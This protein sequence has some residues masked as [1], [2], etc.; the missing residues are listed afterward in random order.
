MEEV[1]L[2][3]LLRVL[4]KRWWILALCAAILG[5]VAYVYTNYYIVPIYESY[6]TLY[7]GK[8]AE[9]NGLAMSD[10]YLGS[11]LISDYREIAKSKQVASEVIKELNLKM[12]AASL[13][14][15]INVSQRSDTRVIQ[16]SIS[17]ANPQ[18]AMDIANKVAEVFQTKVVDIMQVEIVQIIDKAELPSYPIS[19]DENRNIMMGII[20]GFALGVGIV[21]L[22][23]FFNNT[24]KTPEDVRKYV[25]LPV[26]GA[27]P[28]FQT[29][30]RRV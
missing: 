26:I 22:I 10:L 15:R 20:F 12:S 14:G 16:I 23:E 13:A 2:L 9:Q 17:D 18:M 11:Y 7:V 6:T 19:P 25:D 28:V 27:I 24:I 30:G 8:N 5:S 3:K 29:K 4:L 1:N 21:F